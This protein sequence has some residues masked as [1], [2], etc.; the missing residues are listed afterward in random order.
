MARL[1]FRRLL[2][3]GVAVGAAAAYAKRE[4]VRQL[5]PGGGSSSEP[6]PYSPP[7]PAPSNYDA[8]GPPANTATPVPAPEPVVA[9]EPERSEPVEEAPLPGDDPDAVRDAI[10]DA[11]AAQ[12]A[13]TGH[14]A[15]A[16]APAGGVSDPEAGDPPS[17][18]T[19]DAAAGVAP[20]DEPPAA[21]VTGPPNEIETA[22]PAAETKPYDTPEE[23]PSAEADTQVMPD[24]IDEAAEEQAAA[25][26][27]AAIGGSPGN[28]YAGSELGEP[29]TEAERPLAEAGEGVAEG[30][31]QTE[32]ELQENAGPG[33]EGKSDAERQIEDAIEAADNP[34]V[35]ET[36]DPVAPTEEPTKDDDDDISGG[37]WQTWS[38]GAVKPQ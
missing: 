37:D 3:V 4:Q 16:G 24:P 30:Q 9:P 8:P 11:A 31:E 35:G 23:L 18:L 34:A 7:V 27:A 32:A 19:R 2:L 36:P 13:A 20:A 12:Q 38:G 5:L 6:E 28:D 1:T 17:Q 21:D 29:A 14:T 15:S 10:A 25:A 33:D 26:E 22:S